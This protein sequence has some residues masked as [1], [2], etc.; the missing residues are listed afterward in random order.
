MVFGKKSDGFWRK[1][2]LYGISTNGTGNHKPI[3]D[4]ILG[5]FFKDRCPTSRA[6]IIVLKVIMIELRTFSKPIQ[7]LLHT[8][9]IALF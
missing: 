5:I 4:F 6:Y 3:T 1:I 2:L 9:K 8:L 7:N